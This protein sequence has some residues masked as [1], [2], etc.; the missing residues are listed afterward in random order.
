MAKPKVAL[1]GL[2]L[3]RCDIGLLEI[4]E[5]FETHRCCRYHFPGRLPLMLNT[6]CRGYG[7]P[8]YRRLPFNKCVRSSE[9]EHMAKLRG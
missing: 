2:P 6:G 5:I 3:R 1:Y 8:E 9:Q 4:G 7:R